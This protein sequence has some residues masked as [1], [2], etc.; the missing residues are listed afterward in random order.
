MHEVE[1]GFKGRGIPY[2]AQV[3]IRISQVVLE[4][5]AEAGMT[6]AE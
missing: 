1:E 2:F 3:Q 6:R 5:M 4:N